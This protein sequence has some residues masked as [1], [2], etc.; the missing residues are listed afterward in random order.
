MSKTSTGISK[1]NLFSGRK[2]KQIISLNNTTE[3]N[4]GMPNKNAK[5][6][7]QDKK[8]RHLDIRKWERQQKIKR[9]EFLKQLK[10]DSENT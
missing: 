4:T 3:G 10:R 1:T 6:R 9:R 5:K 2:E 8:K 7:K